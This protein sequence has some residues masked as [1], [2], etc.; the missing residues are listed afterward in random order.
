[1][2]PAPPAG[3]FRRETQ[4]CGVEIPGSNSPFA[5]SKAR[6]REHQVKT[7]EASRR[8]RDL[9]EAV[10]QKRSGRPGNT[11]DDFPPRHAAGVYPLTKV[12]DTCQKLFAEA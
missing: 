2:R 1:M 6:L 9:D 8:Q 5:T 7:R 10:G 11:D 4:C 3:P 12:S